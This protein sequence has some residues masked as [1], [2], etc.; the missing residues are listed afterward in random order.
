MSDLL[1]NSTDPDEKLRQGRM[2]TDLYNKKVSDYG[3]GN[4]PSMSPGM[5]GPDYNYVD[6]IATPPQV[7]ARDDP[8]PSGIMNAISA[9]NYYVDVIVFGHPTMFNKN[10]VSPLGIKYF[11]PTG[12]TCSNGAAM[13]EYIDTVPTGNPTAN[14]WAAGAGFPPIQGLAEGILEDAANG[15]NPVPLLRAAAGS[16]YPKCVQITAP[17][18]DADGRIA[19][20]TGSPYVAGPVKDGKQTRWV[21]EKDANG[22]HVFMDMVSFLND[23]K[24]YYPDGTPINTTEEGFLDESF[25]EKYI[26]KRTLVMFLFGG[27][28][29]SMGVFLAHKR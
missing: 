10:P 18:G 21:Q 5:L 11:M 25:L 13:Y 28:V 8:S 12:A 24:I 23:K 7:G 27:L 6:Y 26:D 22:H 2:N 14:R 3:E 17:V 9:M 16:G 15:L 1:G 19:S 29:F 20:P 4:L